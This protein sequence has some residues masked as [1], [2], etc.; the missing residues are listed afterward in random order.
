MSTLIK[1]CIASM[2]VGWII[3]GSNLASPLQTAPQQTTP[4]S[5]ADTGKQPNTPRPNPDPSGKYHIGDGVTP[6]ILVH[7]VEP[8]SSGKMDNVT[9][10]ICVNAAQQY[11]FKPATFQGKPV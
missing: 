11:Q 8:E 10:A 3:P 7:Q 9:E 4:P 2:I 5:P 1:F 6:P